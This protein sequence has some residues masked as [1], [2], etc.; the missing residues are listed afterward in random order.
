MHFDAILLLQYSSCLLDFWYREWLVDI[1]KGS[2]HCLEFE[3]LLGDLHSLLVISTVCI[4]WLIRLVVFSGGYI[5]NV[6]V[7][8]SGT[9][10]IYMYDYIELQ[11]DAEY[12]HILIRHHRNVMWW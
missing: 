1:T 4:L 9:T 6:W 12:F 11:H 10:V 5:W 3:K 7:L 2:G 8:L